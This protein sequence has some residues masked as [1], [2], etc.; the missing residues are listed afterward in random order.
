MIFNSIIPLPIYTPLFYNA[1]LLLIVFAFLK[2]QTNGYV[3][4]SNSKKETAS[5]ILLIGHHRLF[6]Q[7]HR[8]K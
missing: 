7:N 2:L 3:I 5:L 4:Q 1:L 8:Q 6:N